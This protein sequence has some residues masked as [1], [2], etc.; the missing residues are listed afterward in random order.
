M[1][2]P[3][4]FH[5]MFIFVYIIFHEEVLH[6]RILIAE[7][8]RELNSVISRKLMADGNH[9]DSC[10]DG[11]MALEKLSQGNYDVAVLDIMMPGMDGLELVRQ[12][13]N[14]GNE[15]PVLFLTARDSIEDQVT[16]LDVGGDDYLTKPFALEVLSARVRALTRRNSEQR[17][18]TYQV[19]DLTLD[20]KYHRV[21]RGNVEI[22]LSSREFSILEYMMRNAGVILSREQIEQYIWNYEYGGNSNIVDVYIRNLRKKID[23]D[24]EPKLIRTIRMV[25]YTIRGN[26]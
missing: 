11:L 19:E 10:L 17:S 1:G 3:K 18:N 7:D 21:M 2:K 22:E 14:E 6:M 25:G 5:A 4:L 8:E 24:F 15:T 9:V 13:R 12:L 20:V 23:E 16:G 26:K